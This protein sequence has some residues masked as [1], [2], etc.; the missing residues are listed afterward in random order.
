[1]SIS[2][3]QR[4]LVTG[5][6][7]FIGAFLCKKLVE[8]G[9]YDVIGLD[10]L[11]GYYSTDLKHER[12]QMILDADTNGASNSKASSNEFGNGQKTACEESRSRFTFVRGD[13]CDTALLERIFD[14]YQP[15]IVVNLAAQAG[16]RYSIDH[17]REYVDT[18]IVGFF[19]ILE[20]CRAHE[21]SHLIFAS[22]SSIYGD[23]TEVPFSE[24]EPCNQ[25]VS[26][27]AATKKSDE[28][29][30]YSYASLFGLPCT[31]LRFFTVYGPMGRPDM[32]Y[33]HFA[34]CMAA[35]KPVRLFNNG[36]MMRDFTSVDDIVEGMCRVIG[37]PYT[38]V[39]CHQETVP[40]RIF[41]IGHGNPVSLLEFL[42]E[43]ESTLRLAGA[44]EGKTEYE[45]LPMQAGDV[46]QTYADTSAFQREYGY[47]AQTSLSEG[48]SQFA[49]W[50]AQ[51]KRTW[52]S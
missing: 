4:I 41:N 37:K 33:Y 51:R 13:I 8:L 16:V 7:G 32:A 47:T 42:D 3:T 6:A 39:S 52:E 12:L 46:H 14:Q 11:N 9:E 43:L 27:Y 38:E 31:G 17:P 20:Q 23:T 5:A 18:N 36:Q 29:L 21:V 19:N 48:L 25:P 44:I 2:T 49:N 24:T 22:S 30:A 15:E 34:E 1:M 45:Y 50:F 40:Y 10:N 26:L 35:G 28:M